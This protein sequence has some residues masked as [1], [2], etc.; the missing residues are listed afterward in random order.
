MNNRNRANGITIGIISIVLGIL[1][2]ALQFPYITM[3]VILASA[4]GYGLYCVAKILRD[5]IEDHLDEQDK[6]NKWK[7]EKNIK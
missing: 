6:N 4:L 3:M 5:G 2:I 1:I 7:Q